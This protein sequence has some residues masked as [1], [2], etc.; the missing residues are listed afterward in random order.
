M[1]HE[2]TTPSFGWIFSL[3]AEQGALVTIAFARHELLPPGQGFAHESE[4]LKNPPAMLNAPPPDPL[5]VSD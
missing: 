4:P 1:G 5:Q 2:N 3:P